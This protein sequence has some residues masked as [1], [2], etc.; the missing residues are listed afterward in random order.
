MRVS[1][2]PMN[3][4]LPTRHLLVYVPTFTFER[5]YCHNYLSGTALMAGVLW[6]AL[7]LTLFS[8]TRFLERNIKIEDTGDS[9]DYRRLLH[10][11]ATVGNSCQSKLS[12]QRS[13]LA[14][15]RQILFD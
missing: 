2:W 11:H 4:R 12:A 13:G 9:Y 7:F 3:L 14:C 15:H 8:P 6:S 5:L 1:E 10:C